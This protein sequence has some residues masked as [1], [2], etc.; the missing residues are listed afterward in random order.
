MILL[1]SCWPEACRGRTYRRQNWGRLRQANCF[2]FKVETAIS[3]WKL[4]KLVENLALNL[5]CLVVLF[6]SLSFFFFFLLSMAV[7]FLLS[8]LLTIFLML[9]ECSSQ[10][11]EWKQQQENKWCF[12]TRERKRSCCIVG[13]NRNLCSFLSWISAPYL[14]F[15]H[16]SK[17]GFN[18]CLLQLWLQARW[19]LLGETSARTGKNLNQNNYF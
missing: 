18:R 17:F 8:S 16:P 12:W 1:A 9:R 5:P 4:N 14:P 15:P 13:N 11:L 10:R 7:C 19:T 3:N 2:A 6:L